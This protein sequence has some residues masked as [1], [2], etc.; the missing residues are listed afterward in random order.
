MKVLFIGGTGTISSEVSKLA[1]QNGFEL[2]LL[3]RGNRSEFAPSEAR[4]ITCDI[5]DEENA[6]NVLKNY[7]FDAVVNWVCYNPEQVKSDI[8]LFK[9]K[10]NQ[11]IF[12]SSATVYKRPPDHYIIDE[13]VPLSNLHW[14]Y[15]NDKIACEEIL[16]KEYKESGFPVTIVRPSY[17]YSKS[18]IPHIFNSR[19]YHWTIIDR[20]R[21]GRKLIVPG[22]GTSLQ[23]MTHAADLAK[24]F[25]G[26]LG[27]KQAIGQSFQIT[28]DEVL[29][30][31]NLTNIMGAAAGAEADIVHISSDF[32]CAF[33]EDRRGQILS[34]TSLSIVYDNS[35]I[36]SFVSSYKAS[37]PFSEG[38]KQSI[39][40]YDSHSGLRT[41][42]ED[43]N[44]LADKII[45]AYETGLKMA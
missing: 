38:I 21:R 37:I 16:M 45:S 7:E 43:F 4:L 5:R 32:V 41:V 22:D 24:G 15:A 25:V 40:W 35:K 14:P 10:T 20:I 29:T 33:A 34:D 1:V 44:R 2:Y 39:D 3:N 30:W 19:K 11:Y 18:T 8:R 31:N 42:D 27:N 12:I 6:K 26:L 23:I 36:K 9:G 17:T 28:S 13:S